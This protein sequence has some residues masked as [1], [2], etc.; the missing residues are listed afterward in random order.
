MPSRWTVSTTGYTAP[1]RCGERAATTA[2]SRSKATS[3]SAIRSMPWLSTSPGLGGGLADPDAL[4]VVAAADRLEHHRPARR[5]RTP[6]PRPASR[7]RREP[8]AGDAQAGQ[9]L[10]HGQLVLGEAE[11]GGARPDRD[12]V[13]L[14]RGQVLAGHVLVVERDHVAAGREGRAGRPASGSPRAGFR[15]PPG[16]RSRPP[17]PPGPEADAEAG[18]GLAGHPGELA[19]PT[20]PATGGRGRRAASP[21]IRSRSVPY[22]TAATG[23]RLRP[24]CNAIVSQPA[25]FSCYET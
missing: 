17:R 22:G 10:A 13:C 12:A 1:W 21:G 15:P 6:R 8:R 16:P 2:S 11:R 20:M 24:G 14:Q 7:D 9:P 23:L 18:G 25:R 4:A 3:S 19:A 5:R